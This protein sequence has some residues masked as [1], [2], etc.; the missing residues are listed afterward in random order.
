M[1]LDD[2]DIRMIRDDPGRDRKRKEEKKSVPGNKKETITT[3]MRFNDS[4][5]L[6]ISH[7]YPAKKGPAEKTSLRRRG[8]GKISLR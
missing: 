4:A 2:W 6:T 8:G 3:S 5:L 1:I 7:E